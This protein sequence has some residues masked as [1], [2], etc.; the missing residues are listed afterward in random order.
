MDAAIYE[1]ENYSGGDMNVNARRAGGLCAIVCGMM[2]LV[3]GCQSTAPSNDDV[4][5]DDFLKEWAERA[6][7]AKAYLPEEH[8]VES[9]MLDVETSPASVQSTVDTEPVADE[10]T[11]DLQLPDVGGTL[12]TM[13]IEAMVLQ[14]PVEV[15]AFLRSMGRMA[16]QNILFSD[17]IEG[18]VQFKLSS[19]TT[20]DKLFLTLMKVQGLA[21]EWEGNII[22]VL[23]QDDLNHG[24]SMDEV[25]EKR[26][27]VEHAKLQV[28][29]LQI[30]TIRIRYADAKSIRDHLELLLTKETSGADTRRGS[31][32]V[33]T[34]NNAI[35]INAIE[36]DIRKMMSLVSRLD[37]ASAQVLIEAHIVEANK[38]TARELGI[39]WGGSYEGLSANNLL[40]INSGVNSS[41]FMSDFPA[42]L[43]DGAGFSLGGII[44]RVTG[45]QLLKVQLS[46]LEK[47]GRL[48]ILSSPSITTLDNQMAYIESGKEV[49]YQVV[50]GSG[51]SK[52]LTTEWKKALLRLEVTPNVIDNDLVKLKITTNKDELDDSYS[53]DDGLP[54]IITKKAET[55]LIL[56]DGQTT[57]IGGLSRQY[58]QNNRSGI[59][60]LQNIPYA[61]AAFRNKGDSTSME[62]LLIFITPHLLTREEGA[63]D[64]RDDPVVVPP[65]SHFN[66]I[67]EATPEGDL[68][69]AENT[70]VMDGEL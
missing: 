32:A 22:C 20:W 44:Q 69:D 50:S 36:R 38:D 19:S 70:K 40:G 8:V 62:D 29:P 16:Q 43:A 27:Q 6:K 45:T 51:E 26:K 48:N 60:G 34:G 52:D 67:T 49:P 53:S 66:L 15:K 55:T 17:S 24:L 41:G 47:Q 63:N 28:E 3:A 42:D 12:P 68:N 21:Y 5:S 31:V 59:P 23:T 14:K 4:L 30:S 18:T 1:N 11:S 33:D 39:Q 2:L 58:S 46:A 10:S 37:K 61:G 65:E 64:E 25:L 35:I 9:G 13:V 56:R 7:M 54:R 57:V